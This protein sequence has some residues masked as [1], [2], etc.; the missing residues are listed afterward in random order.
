M[1]HSEHGARFHAADLAIE[2]PHLQ[3]LASALIQIA[4]G[5]WSKEIK[6]LAV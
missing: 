6:D 1:N 3:V 2:A 5:D 4:V